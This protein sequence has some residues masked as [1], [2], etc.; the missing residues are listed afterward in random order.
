MTPD[1][2]VEEFLKHVQRR[3]LILH[4]I[5]HVRTRQ[6]LL[7]FMLLGKYNLQYYVAP[8]RHRPPHISDIEICESA[9]LAMW[10]QH[11]K[12]AQLKHNKLY[13]YLSY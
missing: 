12:N 4:C 1:E 10:S 6:L 9:S 5:R 3:R 2:E 8:R 7:Q 13:K 11:L